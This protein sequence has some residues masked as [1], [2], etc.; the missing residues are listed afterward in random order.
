MDIPTTVIPGLIALFLVIGLGGYVITDN[1]NDTLDYT[2]ET[3]VL[4]LIDANSIEIP[5]YTPVLCHKDTSCVSWLNGNYAFKSV[6]TQND[7]DLDLITKEISS[8]RTE[9]ATL[10]AQLAKQK[11]T[12]I[13]IQSTSCVSST[14]D[15]STSSSDPSDIKST[16][17][18]GD[19]VYITGETDPA[20]SNKIKII[21]KSTNQ[22]IEESTFNASTSGVFTRAHITESGSDKGNYTIQIERGNVKS[23]IDFR[24]D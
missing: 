13:N 14:M 6:A 8:M 21:N 16:F 4:K 2:T 22:V 18:R 10:S 5:E 19:I 15:L 24:L 9:I 3:D 7:K 17:T 1:D 12:P 11:N 23:C 20:S